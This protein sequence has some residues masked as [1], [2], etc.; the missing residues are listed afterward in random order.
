[1]WV[2]PK[3]EMLALQPWQVTFRISDKGQ[4]LDRILFERTKTAEIGK[5]T[6]KSVFPNRASH[7]PPAVP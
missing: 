4:S 1:M 3:S 7:R 2:S 6:Y 5:V